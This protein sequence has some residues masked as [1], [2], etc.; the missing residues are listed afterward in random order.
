MDMLS[1]VIAPASETADA[2]LD[3]LVGWSDDGIIRPFVWW[4]ADAS[5]SASDVLAI[6][7]G[8]DTPTN[9]T[10]TLAGF[11]PSEIRF[12]V[13]LPLAPGE[14]IDPGLLSAVDAR[15][16]LA[17]RAVARDV[18]HP[19]T[20]AVLVI[21]AVAG[22]QIPR[23][24]F[25]PEWTASLYV[26][27]ED[28]RTPDEVD[29]MAD[30]PERLPGHAAHAVA[31]LA[32]LLQTP[33]H[34]EGRV[35]DRLGSQY[36]G[37]GSP[38]SARVVR[39]FSRLV[40]HGY[41]VDRLA[42]EV[43]ARADAWPNPDPDRFDRP[44]TATEFVKYLSETFMQRHA[45]V[46]GPTKW[47]PLELPEPE[48]PG[49]LEALKLLFAILIG[50]AMRYP[51]T[52]VENAKAAVHDRAAG[53]IER[54]AGKDSG[55]SVK[56]YAEYDTPPPSIEDAL[57]TDLERPANISDGP[58]GDTWS[59]LVSLSV[60]LVDGAEIPE[61]LDG[62]VLRR[63][64]KRLVITQPSAIGPDPLKRPPS[65]PRPARG[66]CDPLILDP[67]FA[68]E[69]RVAL[70]A[71]LGPSDDDVAA[72]LSTDSKGWA[73]R[74]RDSLLWRVGSAIS[75]NLV[76]A[77][78]TAAAGADAEQQAARQLEREA[79]EQAAAVADRRSLRR[80]IRSLVVG[81]VAAVGG[82][83]AAFVLLDLIL[84]FPAAALVCAGW[85][86]LLLRSAQRHL[87]G[88]RQREF[89]HLRAEV[90]RINEQI[91]RTVAAA[92]VGRLKRRYDEFVDWA[93][94]IG[95]FVHRPWIGDPLATRRLPSTFDPD[96][97]PSAMD[98]RLADV[99]PRMQVL[100][101]RARQRVFEPRW[102]TR[103]A[104]SVIRRSAEARA[105]A[106]DV[107]ATG[108]DVYG[109]KDEDEHSLRRTLLR[110]VRSGRFAI[111]SENPMA[112]SLARHV[113]GLGIDEVS[114]GVEE[115]GA[116]DL[117]PPAPSSEWFSEPENLQELIDA[118]TP[119]VVRVE[120]A[121]GSGSGA[122]L[123]GDP[124]IVTARHVVDGEEE[125]RVVL[126]DG[127]SVAAV[128]DTLSHD[129]D[130]AL[131]RLAEDIAHPRRLSLRDA[132]EL[133]DQGLPVVILDHRLGLEGEPSLGWGMITATDRTLPF[134]GDKR[135]KVYQATYQGA[136]GASGAPV[137]DLEGRLVGVHQGGASPDG[138]DPRAATISFAVPV[139]DVRALLGGVSGSGDAPAA[140][141]LSGSPAFDRG[142][143]RPTASETLTELA[144]DYGATGFLP[145]H[146]QGFPDRE[147]YTV[148][149]VAP[150]VHVVSAETPV[151]ELT[152]GP[153]HF[154]RPVRVVMR[155]I[156][157]TP[158][159][160][161]DDLNGV[162]SDPAD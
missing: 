79:A 65:D 100:A 92:D 145:V 5:A 41:L 48:R 158:E 136:G 29:R 159:A 44:G 54:L 15:L 21:P 4:R 121:T 105:E 13:V 76:T 139:G 138:T 62:D 96:T 122:V 71:E 26:A 63:E 154:R 17:R 124:R 157:A 6:T 49:L 1:I 104:E 113:A 39:C 74:Q 114:A 98:T 127:R 85:A 37:S 22:T 8:T 110:D 118:V 53:T 24:V 135:A 88:R 147:A 107:D 66:P 84:A 108:S 132:S 12:Y 151:G 131:L 52:V 142:E 70:A 68:A 50:R 103:L 64:G 160:A 82:L 7:G 148:D 35:V 97:A 83:I 23:S 115:A 141:T 87:F 144:E 36:V 9:L 153:V 155:R 78:R 156:E 45:D 116:S 137:V 69:G 10:A 99:E 152:A 134:D 59:D 75:R 143:S 95:H 61:G 57:Q 60:S 162:T 18:E 55:L 2:V 42:V 146:F 28:R 120:T 91:A 101:S 117:V 128:V 32:D 102:L 47:S 125:V 31:L 140:A 20:P 27:P 126:A 129:A 150:E 133:V 16:D 123:A 77:A 93:E 72:E 56:R 58:V 90:A 149:V 106:Y 89:D 119:A 33:A 3:R 11:E 109:D 14:M 67:A 30:E 46:L 86:L 81:S 19:V 51:R 130:V 112:D 80:L 73:A 111:I 43:F 94:I 25:R 40:D 34:D 38:T 161:V